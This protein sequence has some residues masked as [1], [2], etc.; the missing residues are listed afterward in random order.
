[1]L[2]RSMLLGLACVLS[3]C[4]GG[5]GGSSSGDGGANSSSGNNSPDSSKITVVH[6][7]SDAPNVNVEINGVRRVTDLGF[8]QGTGLQ[9]LSVS[10]ASVQLEPLFD[11]QQPISTVDVFP[12]VD[13]SFDDI[14]LDQ[15]LDYYVVALGKIENNSL[16]RVVIT[17]EQSVS[18]GNVSIS[19]VNA[20]EEFSGNTVVDA[21]LTLP[22]QPLTN[23]VLTE[24]GLGF[25]QASEPV[26]VSAGTFQ[27]R[28]TEAGTE[29]VLFD[30]TLEPV[31]S[32][33]KLLA[34]ALDHFGAGDSN[35]QLLMLEA[36]SGDQN[37][38][39]DRNAGA[40]IRLV[41]NVGDVYYRDLEATV[42]GYDITGQ[43][44]V[45]FIT[46]FRKVGEYTSVPAGTHSFV[47]STSSSE[48]V[49]DEADDVSV[50]LGNGKRYTA[51]VMGQVGD[52]RDAPEVALLEDDSR[53]LRNLA[54]ARAVQGYSKGDD[55]P[56]AAQLVLGFDLEVVDAVITNGE[57]TPGTYRTFDDIRYGDVRPADDYVILLPGTYTPEVLQSNGAD[58][59]VEL[60]IPSQNLLPSSINT[61]VLGDD[62]A[63]PVNVP[64]VGTVIVPTF[65]LAPLGLIQAAT[66]CTRSPRL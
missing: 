42:G 11:N 20:I 1:M 24:N 56:A 63:N 62:E 59:P 34:V 3:A 27:L 46:G 14:T 61:I 47:A 7:V 52:S 44:A 45:D 31:E 13:F 66:P 49:I 4:G 23:S 54:K 6:A 64:L 16:D 33:D 25:G 36:E 35:I 28:F 10:N 40:E 12:G 55:V 19:I 32:G 30:A 41:H 43:G 58:I 50:N 53:V 17:A 8:A 5:G 60:P 51:I 18:S 65:A 48:A 21:Y 2:Y 29:E 26:E 22:G 15:A 37:R 57:N 38:F 39:F 9:D